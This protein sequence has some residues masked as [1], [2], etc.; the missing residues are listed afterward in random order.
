LV[1]IPSWLVE[2]ALRL[3]PPSVS[4]YDRLGRLRMKLEKN[5]VYF[6]AGGSCPYSVEADG[7]HQP[8]TSAHCAE[9]AL[10]TD[11]L[12]NIDFYMAMAHCGD[13]PAESRDVRELFTV[14][15]H[16]IKPVIIT[17]HTRR[18]L[19]I[20]VQMCATINGGRE[21]FLGKPYLIYYTEPVSPLQHTAHSV[22]KLLAAAE[23][24]LPI[25]NT[26][27]PMAGATAPITLAGTLLSGIAELLSGIVLLQNHR[28]GSSVI[29]GGVFTTLDMR[30]MIFTYG[31]PE[32]QL[33]NTAIAQ[34]AQFYGIPS[35]GTA[36][37]TDA[38]EV[39]AQ[40]AFEC[41]TSILLNALSGS[42]LV[43]DVGWMSSAQATS[44]EL[45]ILGDEMIAYAK[46][47]LSGINTDLMEQSAKE[48]SAVGPGGNFIERDLT[49]ELYRKE[50]WYPSL[51]RR[52]PQKA[53]RSSD[54]RGLK[55]RLANRAADILAHHQPPP[56][57][58]DRLREIHKL[59]AAYEKELA[60]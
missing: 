48:L 47:Y 31:G 59:I 12:E 29:F 13:F 39:D 24:G 14:L 23:Y 21:R 36:G 55:E 22:D 35:F 34:L 3:T 18:S 32:L 33:M 16:T 53:W 46:R 45:L 52:V 56:I 27:A 5:N 4:V 30:D 10:I 8:F 40:A 28:Q 42:N 58:D 60:A 15:S 54:K 49:L 26:P 9:N 19:E 25:L 57:P 11:A 6:G 2:Q 37:A 51:L 20:I 38:H 43:H 1:K 7:S 17:S 41:G 44:D 50:V